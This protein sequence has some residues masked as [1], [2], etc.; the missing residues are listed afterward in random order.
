MSNDLHQLCANNGIS[1]FLKHLT[2]GQENVGMDFDT[3]RDSEIP[4]RGC[5][6]HLLVDHVSELSGQLQK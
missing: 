1:C 3:Q 6:K 2:A 4:H 5:E